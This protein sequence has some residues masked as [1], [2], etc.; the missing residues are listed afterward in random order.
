MKRI[1]YIADLRSHC[2]NGICYA[3]KNQIPIV[4][5]FHDCRAFTGG[6]PYIDEVK[7]EM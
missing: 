7:C 4:W 2:V 1:L 3:N 6:C 5:T